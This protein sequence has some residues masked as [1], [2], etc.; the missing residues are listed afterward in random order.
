MLIYAYVF[1]S[2]FTA[3]INRRSSIVRI[4]KYKLLTKQ[5]LKSLGVNNKVMNKVITYLQFTFQK[6]MIVDTSFIS[7]LA[8]TIKK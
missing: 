6:D 1:Q 5:Y 8:P 3:I 2:I 4:R 7:D